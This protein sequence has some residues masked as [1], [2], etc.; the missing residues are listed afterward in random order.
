[1]SK[2][3]SEDPISV[4]V[5][6]GQAR[7]DGGDRRRVQIDASGQIGS[8]PLRQLPGLVETLRRVL[9]DELGAVDLE[10]AV[11]D[12]E[13]NSL[14]QRILMGAELLERHG[15]H[16]TALERQINERQQAILVLLEQ[17]FIELEIKSVQRRSEV[18][19]DSAS[20]AALRELEPIFQKAQEVISVCRTTGSWPAS[21]ER[22]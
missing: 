14:E 12:I 16:L 21:Q 11:V 2:S 6:V 10:R 7:V 8:F 20:A 18:D 1:M 15:K 13:L 17:V 9:R 19:K 4:S 22:A 3:Y 5:Y